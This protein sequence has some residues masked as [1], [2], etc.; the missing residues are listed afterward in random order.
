MFRLIH[1]TRNW[2][3]LQW[4]WETVTRAVSAW[5]LF[6]PKRR[7]IKSPTLWNVYTLT[8]KAMTH[9]SNSDFISSSNLA[10]AMV[11]LSYKQPPSKRE[12]IFVNEIFCFRPKPPLLDPSV[13]VNRNC[14]REMSILGTV[15]WPLWKHSLLAGF[16]LLSDPVHCQRTGVSWGGRTC[17]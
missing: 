13:G 14:D 15:S 4:A 7:A 17:L 6:M 3:D 8:P 16:R 1:S 9:R 5:V 11:Q 12:N 2:F 10:S